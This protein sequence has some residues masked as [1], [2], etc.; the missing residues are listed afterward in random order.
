[1]SI[2][3]TKIDG[4]NTISGRV[5][6]VGQE[7]HSGITAVLYDDWCENSGFRKAGISD[8]QGYFSIA[9]VPDCRFELD[10]SSTVSGILF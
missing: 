10:P 4:E 2:E 7:D 1:M 9:G 8:K 5:T 6:M 3:A